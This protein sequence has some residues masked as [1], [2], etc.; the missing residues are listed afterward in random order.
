MQPEPNIVKINSEESAWEFLKQSLD[1]AF[2]G[3]DIQVVF[4]NWPS[5]NIHIDKKG[6]NSSLNTKNM[7]GLIELQKTINRSF[8]ILAYDTPNTNSLTSAE[9][10]S[11]ELLFK[12]SEG[13]TGI[14]AALENAVEKITEKVVNKME[15]KHIAAVAIS[16]ALLW[17]GHSCWSS[18]LQH[19]KEIKQ[20]EHD[21][22][23]RQFASEEEYKKMKLIS[24]LAAHVPQLNAVK[25]KSEDMYNNVLKS[26]SD[27]DTV[28][29]AGIE[30]ISGKTVQALVKTETEKTKAVRIDG[31]YRILKVDASKES[32][33]KVC[34][35]SIDTGQQFIALVNDSFVT[36]E[37]YKKALQNAEWNKKPVQLTV[38]ARVKKESV[39]S[40]TIIDV[41]EI[42]DPK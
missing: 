38:N 24:D 5:I 13:T 40:A 34:V 1:E 27:A 39:T 2:T 33:F 12:I 31:A 17:T 23:S 28:S 14:Q 36:Q 29:I 37:K 8:S 19:Q 11:L 41:E 32:S 42:E 25:A 26:V 35:R 3:T 30:D 15:S 9:K 21:V 7:E 22:E 10:Q 6:Q 4:E 20:I 16:A 18:W